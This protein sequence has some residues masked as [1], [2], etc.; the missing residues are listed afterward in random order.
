MKS[1]PVLG[2]NPLCLYKHVKKIHNL[3]TT[4]SK[5]IASFVQFDFFFYQENELLRDIFGLGA[6]I[7]V[8]RP[9]YKATKIERVGLLWFTVL[10]TST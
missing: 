8:G 2:G 1:R 5:I 4:W 10:S 7:P 3:V 6:P 9:V